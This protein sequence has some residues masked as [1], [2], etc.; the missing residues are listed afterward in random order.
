MNNEYERYDFWNRELKMQRK[1]TIE[2]NHNK[3]EVLDS[4][5]T[6]ESVLEE[7]SLEEKK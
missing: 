5:N 3:E 6:F 4:A 1:E 7:D 2:C